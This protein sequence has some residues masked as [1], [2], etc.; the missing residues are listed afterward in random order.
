MSY[1]NGII[2]GSVTIPDLQAALST[3]TTSVVQLCKHR[4]INKYSRYKPYAFGGILPD[5]LYGASGNDESKIKANNFGMTPAAITK[6]KQY[7]M[8]LANCVGHWGQWR[9]PSGKLKV[10]APSQAED[11]PCRTGDFR[12]YSKDAKPHIA[13]IEWFSMNNQ[14]MGSPALQIGG[15]LKARVTVNTQTNYGIGL[16][17]FSYNG[18]ALSGL[19]LTIV[20]VNYAS[21]NQTWGGQMFMVAQSSQSLLA[22]MTANSTKSSFTWE[23]SLKYPNNNTFFTYDKAGNLRHF[24]AIGLAPYKSGITDSNGYAQILTPSAGN[25][26]PTLVNL[27][28]WGNFGDNRL[29]AITSA[30][31]GI[32][33]FSYF[34]VYSMVRQASGVTPTFTAQFITKNGTK[35]IAIKL[36]DKFTIGTYFSNQSNSPYYIAPVNITEGRLVMCY[37]FSVYDSSF[38]YFRDYCFMFETRKGFNAQYGTDNT[39]TEE[40][41]LTVTD[42]QV[43]WTDQGQVTPTATNWSPLRDHY[44]ATTDVKITQ[45]EAA[46]VGMFINERDPNKEHESCTYLPFYDEIF[47]PCE[48]TDV[49][50]ALDRRLL[51]SFGTGAQ[52]GV[53]SW[54]VVNHFTA[55]TGIWAPSTTQISIRP[56]KV[57][58]P[59]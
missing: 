38:D 53:I 22:V 33:T 6:P 58:T 57:V 24:I 8:T 25:A 45:P 35:G 37:F 59:T 43:K 47:I 55:G 12:N 56:N 42:S 49:V 50:V 9:R 41:A 40:R 21:D 16:N 19:Y 23:V 32:T 18:T 4:S 20:A 36:N 3:T 26:I 30:W 14:S 51:S 5:G 44:Q 54:P 10:D 29:A 39:C 46:T 2:S 34:N 1:T 52:G 7:E 48:R 31:S 27:D 17:E 28:A 15:A 13:N 11:E